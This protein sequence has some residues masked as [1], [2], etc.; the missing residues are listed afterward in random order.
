VAALATE[1][2]ELVLRL[3]PLEKFGALHGDIRVPLAA[4]SSVAV[5]SN[6]WNELRGLRA[7]GTG[8]PGVIML[9]TSRGPFGKDFAAIYVRRPAVLVELN[10]QAFQHLIVCTADPHGDHA[11]LRQQAPAAGRS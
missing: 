3:N 5:V 11:L 7:P 1:G 8:F 4:I 6:P 2:S 10:G 9:G